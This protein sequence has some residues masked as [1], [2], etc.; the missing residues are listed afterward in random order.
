MSKGPDLLVD[1]SERGTR[2]LCLCRSSVSK[3]A[4][5]QL[6]YHIN[7]ATTARKRRH[8]ERRGNSVHV[9][10]QRLTQ[11]LDSIWLSAAAAT[12]FLLTSTSFHLVLDDAIK[13]CLN[14]YRYGKFD[15]LLEIRSQGIT[16]QRSPLY[17]HII[18]VLCIQHLQL[19]S[20][21]TILQQTSL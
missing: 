5:I 13:I 10:R 15:S 7:I 11:L 3:R 14:D 21:N 16:L 19:H 2:S 20:F 9:P 1:E 8:S 18:I 4:V 17:L 12:S 6:L